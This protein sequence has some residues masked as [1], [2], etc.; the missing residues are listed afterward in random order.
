MELSC[1]WM[2]RNFYARSAANNKSTISSLWEWEEKSWFDWLQ[3]A[4]QENEWEQINWIHEIDLGGFTSRGEQPSQSTKQ[5]SN[6]F[7]IC[8]LVNWW[9]CLVG[10]NGICELI[11]FLLSLLWGVMG[12]ARPALLR[13]ERENKAR[14]QINETNGMKAERQVAQLRQLSLSENQWKKWNWLKKRERAAASGPPRRHTAAASQRSAIQLF[15]MKTIECCLRRSQQSSSFSSSFFFFHWKEKQSI[16]FRNWAGIE[17]DL[18]LFSSLLNWWV[19]SGWPLLCREEI[20]FHQFIHI[21]WFHFILLAFCLNWR[22]KKRERLN[23]LKKRQLSNQS[24]RNEGWVW[25][26]NNI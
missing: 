18:L 10:W 19:M 12:G 25:W 24:K 20:P 11:C 4:A 21:H 16:Q 26:A 8:L 14:K 5:Q 6:Q 17:L 13:K 9:S 23:L 22:K 1:C 2:K 3:L 15:F 7:T